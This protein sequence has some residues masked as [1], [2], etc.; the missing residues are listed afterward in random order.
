MI[1][2][3]AIEKAC[4]I[5]DIDKDEFTFAQFVSVADQAQKIIANLCVN[6]IS[7]YSIV[8]T[9]AG[10]MKYTMPDDFRELIRIKRHLSKTPVTYELVGNELFI[11]DI[12]QFDVF[13][14]ANPSDIDKNTSENYAFEV[15]K[16]TH[17]AIP[18]YIVYQLCKGY[19]TTTAQA[20]LTEWNKYISLCQRKTKC[21][22]KEIINNY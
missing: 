13:Y 18:Y 8:K 10:Q 15:D 2:K 5:G 7:N 1:L 19:D 12:G 17:F 20:A 9:D 4:I 22:T 21:V 14:V 3:E 6:I 16:S 11:D